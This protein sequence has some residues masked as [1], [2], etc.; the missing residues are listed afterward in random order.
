MKHP[1]LAIALIPI[2]A[3]AQD[4]NCPSYPQSERTELQRSIEL[5]QLAAHY[6]ASVRKS[7]AGRIANAVVRSNFIDNRIFDKM[8]QDRV[9]SAG[10]SGDAEFLRRVSVHLTGR[11]PSSEK[12]KA[13][14]ADTATEKRAR[15]IEELLASPAYND[16]WTLFFS[17]RF[18]V[19]SG[20]YN[21]I[22]LQGRN[23]F[24]KFLRDFVTRDRSYKDVVTEMLTASGDADANGP[25]NFLIRAWQ[26]G[27]PI[28]DTWDTATD[29]MTTR[30]LG[31]KTECISCHDGRNHLEQINVFMTQRRRSE[32]Y[33]MSAFFSRT[34]YQR[35]NVDGFGQRARFF[36]V[37][38]PAGAYSSAVDPNNPGPR[39]TR[40]GGPYTPKWMLSGE[41]PQSNEW[42]GDLA[43]ILTSDRQFARATVNYLWA[44]LF[45]YGLVDPADGWDLA[46]LD[47]A[48]PPQGWPA[49]LLHPELLDELAD[50]FIANNYSVKA[51]LRLMANSSAYQLSS[52][53]DGQWRP[54]F[55][56]YFAKHQPR[57]LAAEE[58]WDAISSAT[59]TQTPMTVFG[60]DEPLYYANQLPDP[61]EPRSHGSVV[62]FMNLFGRGDWWTVGRNSDPSLLQLLYTMN[63]SQV[64]L[65]TF[66]SRADATPNRVAR[67]AAMPVSDEEAIQELF[68]STLSRRANSEEL[69]AVMARK[70]GARIDWMAD[71]QWALLNKLDFIFNY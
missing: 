54:E 49:Q 34:T 48:K 2:L 30:I 20:Y 27:D 68:L 19:T 60:F 4:T 25:A 13:F 66:A 1:T 10:P 12:V 51:L 6:A 65:R 39:P 36:L 43:R 61:T 46:R 3:T 23:L 45:N 9:L 26:D 50:H 58:M 32:F 11:I 15:L 7:K 18:Q 53:Y 14:L 44:A 35:L 71:L 40:T 16:Q 21:Y 56:R 5:D 28:Q 55:T 42:R 67:V 69:A 38:R 8:D 33:G 22:G 29:R 63:D 17:N 62:N 24:H 59:D 31:L 41:T 57:R 47:P 70:K 64:V 37:D 52:R